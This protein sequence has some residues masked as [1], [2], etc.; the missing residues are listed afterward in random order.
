MTH[1]EKPS[2]AAVIKLELVRDFIESRRCKT[3]IGI[4]TPGREVRVHDANCEKCK[5][6]RKLDAAIAMLKKEGAG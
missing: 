1:E 5:A 2:S 3:Y 6:M 4:V